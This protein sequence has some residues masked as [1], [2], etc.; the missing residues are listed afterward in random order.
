MFYRIQLY[1][2]I[3]L[4][5]AIM[6]ELNAR[7]IIPKYDMTKNNNDKQILSNYYQTAEM[8]DNMSLD[9]QFLKVFITC[10]TQDVFYGV[11]SYN[12]DG[13]YIMALPPE[14]CKIIGQYTSGDFAYAF[15]M[16][17][18]TG[19]NREYVDYWGEPFISMYKEYEKDTLNN[20]W[21]IMPE[22]YSACFKHNVEDWMVIVPPFSGLLNDIISLEDTKNVQAVADEQDIYKIILLFIDLLKDL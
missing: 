18:F 6:F 16:M 12:D 2:R 4:Y 15:N 19:A 17:Y 5:N 10:F 14:Y 1:R 9:G 8:L 21:I 20:R 11:A 7:S 13:L 22:K 3:I